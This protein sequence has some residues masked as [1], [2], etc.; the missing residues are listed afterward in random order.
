MNIRQLAASVAVGAVVAIGGTVG[1]VASAYH[2][3][4]EPEN[5]SVLFRD[6][7]QTIPLT[8]TEAPTT[9]EPAPAEATAEA[10]AP[11]EST[12]E[13]APEPVKTEEPA[14]PAK[15]KA[16]IAPD[17]PIRNVVPPV[18]VGGVTDAQGNFTP[19]VH[20]IPAPTPTPTP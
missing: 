7:G 17:D 6:S 20:E 11:V 2:P 5:R 14:V 1:L 9:A 4:P 13:P 8:P 15:P 18:G 10:P 19:G 3:Q 16:E 12:S